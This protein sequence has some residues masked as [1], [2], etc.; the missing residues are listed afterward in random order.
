MMGQTQIENRMVVDSEWER[1]IP[2]EVKKALS[3]HGYH[4]EGTNVFVPDSQAY[5]Y[6]LERCL[7]GSEDDIKEFKTM[8]VEWFYSGGNWR[9]EEAWENDC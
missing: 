3:E 4:E 7:Y 6:A 5:E 9:R 8:L 1:H 2:A